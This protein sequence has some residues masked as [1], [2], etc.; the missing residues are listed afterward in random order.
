MKTVNEVALTV[1]DACSAKNEEGVITSF[2]YS[3]FEEVVKQL[4]D[5]KKAKK[6]RGKSL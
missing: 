3:F 2:N 4:N 5:F 1:I 6:R